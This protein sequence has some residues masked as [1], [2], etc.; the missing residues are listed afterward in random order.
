MRWIWC[1]VLAVVVWTAQAGAWGNKEHIQLTRLAAERLLADAQTPAEMKAW[2]KEAVPGSMD[3]A[4][5]KEYFLHKHVG[6]IVRG[7]DG[8]PY[9]ATMPDMI[10]MTEAGD[11]ER[12][13]EPFGVSE[14]VLHYID[15]ELF[16]PNPADRTYAPDLSH[17]PNLADIPRDMTDARFKQA[18]HVALPPSKTA[19]SGWFRTS[20]AT[21]LMM[22][23]GSTRA[24]GTPPSGPAI[25]RITRPTTRNHIIQRWTTRAAHISR[26]MSRPPMPTAK[27]STSCAMTR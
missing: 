1:V 17:K 12:K 23:R 22:R 18:G 27:S 19:S 25:S 13:V 8:L 9:W 6:I 24:T 15:V 10:A 5:E 2:L 11:R 21:G 3:M 7:V 4:G 26:P 16:M 20:A 14:R